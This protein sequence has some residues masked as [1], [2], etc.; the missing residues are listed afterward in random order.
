MPAHIPVSVRRLVAAVLLTSMAASAQSILADINVNPTAETSSNPRSFARLGNEVLFMAETA[1]HG[2][3]LWK[4]D[5]S[6]GTTSLVADIRPDAQGS[7]PVGLVT[8]GN[9]VY[10]L[11]DDGVHG[12]ELWRSDGTSTGTVLVKDIV[13]GSGN[14]YVSELTVAG[15]MMFFSAQSAAG[16]ELWKTDGTAAGTQ[17]VADIEPGPISSFPSYL[18]EF[19][20]EVYF[21]AIT[22]ATGME[23]WKSDGTAA[24]TVQVVDAVPGATSSFA[25]NF[26][27][28]G[29]WMVFTAG[30]ALWRTDGTTTG[31]SI[32][33]LL[34]AREIVSNGTI[35]YLV[36][37]SAL[38]VTDGTAANT[39]LVA[40][41]GTGM[42][43]L[44]E[45][46]TMFGSSVAVNFRSQLTGQSTLFTS[47]GT[48]AGT[49]QVHGM[50]PNS[51]STRVGLGN[52][53]LFTGTS[54]SGNEL[55]VTDGTLAGTAQLADIGIGAAS[56]SPGYLTLIG[57]NT[58]MFNA[59]DGVHGREPWI[60][61]GTTSGTHLVANINSTAGATLG[62]GAQ[63]FVD[64]GGTAY[65]AAS[66]DGTNQTLWRTDGTA[67]GTWAVVPPGVGRPKN[68]QQLTAV[69]TKLF[70]VAEHAQL[71]VELWVSDGTAAGTRVALDAYVGAGFGNPTYLVPA[72]GW[73][74]FTAFSPAFSR[75]LW[76]TD[77][78][79]AG[80][81]RLTGIPPSTLAEMA[82]LGRGLVFS[83]N[84]FAHGHEPYFTDGT[85]A[86]TVLL[87]DLLPGLS[88][89][90]PEQITTLG[91][92]C[93]FTINQK[94]AMYVTDGT[95]A[96][97]LQFLN[98]MPGGGGYYD[99]FS[100]VGDTLYFAARTPAAGLELWK[101]DGTVAGSSLVL[102][103]VPGS[104][105]TYIYPLG[106]MGD[107]YLYGAQTSGAG[108]QLWRSNGTAAGTFPILLD[109]DASTF[110]AAGARNG[111]FAAQDATGIELW[112]TD[113][114]LAGTS[115]YADLFPGEIS[116]YPN[117]LAISNGKLLFCAEHPTLGLEPWIL[118]LGATSQPVGY[119]CLTTGGAPRL[120]STDP[121]LGSTVV[122]SVRNGP[123]QGFGI[124]GISLTTTTSF[125]MPGGVCD[126]FLNPTY[127]VFAI[128]LL[129][130][131]GFDVPL[132]LPNLPAYTGLPLRA[133]VLLVPGSLVGV[134]ATNALAWVLGQ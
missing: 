4:T 80:T 53:L 125:R 70:F 1:Q 3:E 48:A 29:A 43:E 96:G 9:A 95:P 56:S 68:P 81:V 23:P 51:N 12:G 103:A 99:R 89:S 34:P 77:G 16:Q 67:A 88:G 92:R 132:S 108:R 42:F 75:A 131:G 17:Q 105:G 104:D 91:D 123:A 66:D 31:T 69:G 116:S 27:T 35:A 110:V 24:G 40:N 72:A 64:A 18:H 49:I 50:V 32:L 85:P 113:G 14:S 45:S 20:G 94:S 118:Q 101:T 38:Y 57:N 130:N 120:S 15:G 59:D 13:P 37:G 76:R 79:T 100:V 11:A 36:A 30:S 98:L 119:P 54:T 5:L 129:A 19:Q 61:D 115:R 78:T 46:M 106:A 134:E 55:W 74:Y 2:K 62:S 124:L 133:Q 128:P 121:V 114:T 6:T 47:D 58:V 10:F 65:F 26:T 90:S 44:L 63:T 127:D 109:Q 83:K 93:F 7:W 87:G 60:T 97:T 52:T 82:P 126:L 84:D 122:L 117:S 8:F 112:H 111:W 73:L 41:I 86:G 33:Q 71:G 21:Q 22:T 102:D 107:L 28:V 39:Q 25:R